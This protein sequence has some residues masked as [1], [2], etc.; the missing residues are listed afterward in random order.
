MKTMVGISMVCKG[1]IYSKEVATGVVTGVAP[2]RGK[3]SCVIVLD[4]NR[5]EGCW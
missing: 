4:Y 2:E 3:G 1:L 5:E